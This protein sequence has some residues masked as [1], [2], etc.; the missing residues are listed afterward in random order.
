MSVTFITGNSHKARILEQY[1]DF[2]VKHQKI[3]LDEIQSLDLREITE[4]KVKQAFAIIKTPV[5]V[6]DV[7][8]RFETWGNLPGPLIK[9]FVEEMG[10]ERICRQLDMSENRSATAMITFAYYDGKKLEFFDGEIAGTISEKP[11]GSDFGWN[12]IF[13]P[14]G[15]D[16]T[17]GEMDEQNKLAK[18]LRT[19]TVFPKIKD[20][21]SSID[22]KS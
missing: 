19:A 13:T 4:H 7:G 12:P 22:K 8:L 6:E 9:W 2:P 16:M 1:L 18:G 14:N 5:L 20:F 21:L 10:L 3:S 11:R 15:S 17:Y